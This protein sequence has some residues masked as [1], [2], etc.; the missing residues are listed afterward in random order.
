[1]G[2]VDYEVTHARPIAGQWR[3]VGATVALDPAA[4]KYFL[5]PYGFGLKV[6]VAAEVPVEED[7]TTSVKAFGAVGD[8]APAAATEKAPGRRGRKAKR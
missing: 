3:E 2:K 5:P 7:G 6:P 1:M 4:A 8:D